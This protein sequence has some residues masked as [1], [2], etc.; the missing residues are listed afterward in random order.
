M[1]ETARYHSKMKISVAIVTRNRSEQLKRCLL[2]LTKQVADPHEVLVVDNSS[3]DNTKKIV[4]TFKNKLP[5]RYLTEQRIG[6]TFARNTALREA[7][8]DI[9]AFIDD[10]CEADSS[11]V[12]NIHK[13]HHRYPKICA[14]QGW[15]ESLPKN[16]LISKI[17]Q[18]NKEIGLRDNIIIS[19]I[20]RKDI[21]KSK[22]NIL[23]LDA[24]NMSLKKIIVKRLGIKFDQSSIEYGYGVD[25]NLAKQLLALKQ[26]IVFNPDIKVYHWERNNVIALCKQSFVAGRA[27]MEVRLKWPSEYFPKRKKFW[28]INRLITFLTYYMDD[29]KQ[30]GRQLLFLFPFF[31]FERSLYFLGYLYE[32]LVFKPNTLKSSV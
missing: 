21:L 31:I 22:S 5:I 11:W 32:R 30:E 19:T 6:M 9:I 1:A 16:S 28:W 20:K 2:S 3:T 7:A 29:K 23:L 18:F 14:I 15:F 13:A 24:K 17:V 27:S 4:L 26:E 10:D 25:Y 12:R 8:G